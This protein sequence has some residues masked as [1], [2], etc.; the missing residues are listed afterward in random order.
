M[1]SSVMPNGCLISVRQEELMLICGLCCCN[2][3]CIAGHYYDNS[4]K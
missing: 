3:G 2:G 1:S 4:G